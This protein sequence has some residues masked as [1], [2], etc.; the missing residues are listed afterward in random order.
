MDDEGCFLGRWSL[1]SHRLGL[2]RDIS[3]DTATWLLRCYTGSE[4]H[5]HGIRHILAM[6]ED[7]DRL[8][9]E[10]RQPLAA[11]LA[12]FFH[13]AI[14]DA[15]RS[16]NETRSAEEL[17]K[18]LGNSIGTEIVEAACSMIEATKAHTATGN[19]DAD[20]LIDLDMAI[21][22]QDWPIY[23]RYARDV[24]REYVPFFGE[25]AYQSGRVERFLKPTISDGRIFLTDFYRPLTGKARENMRR[26]SE[27]L[28]SGASLE[29]EAE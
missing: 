25:T 2:S 15:S 29:K 23:L 22:A 8:K 4:R 9:S 20:L 27:L 21:L 12:I 19:S 11:E 14:Y 3:A 10:F 16:D 28:A 17:R 24:M 13:D 7:F 6:L 18:S 26:E 1:L 5:Y